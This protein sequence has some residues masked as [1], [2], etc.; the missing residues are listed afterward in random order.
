M[1]T[2]IVDVYIYVQ[3][4]DKPEIISNL[5]IKLGKIAGVEKAVINPRIKQL[6]AVKYN[7]GHVSAYTILSTVKQ[8]GY[9]VSLVGL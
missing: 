6:L 5:L 8:D 1:K 7:P 3:S 4:K 2:N 9:K